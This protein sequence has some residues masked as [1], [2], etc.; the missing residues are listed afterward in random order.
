MYCANCGTETPAEDV[1]RRGP[2]ICCPECAADLPGGLKYDTDKIRYDL[3]PPEVIREL[4]KILTYGANKYAANNWQG[5]DDF[6]ARYTAALFRHLEAWRMGEREDPESGF[7]HL[8]HALCNLA[9][10]VWKDWQDERDG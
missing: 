4:A 8:S 9:F 5:L 10:L 6:E 2:S 7:R 1:V 3:V